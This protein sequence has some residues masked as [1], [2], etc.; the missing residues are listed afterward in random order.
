MS[1][2]KAGEERLAGMQTL[3]ERL[4][5]ERLLA[6]SISCPCFQVAGTNMNFVL[7]PPGL[8][9]GLSLPLT[10][11][12][13]LLV[14]TVHEV[15]LA[16]SVGLELRYLVWQQVRNILALRPYA[17][18]R[19]YLKAIKGGALLAIESSLAFEGL[20]PRLKLTFDL[21]MSFTESAIL[22]APMS[23]G[24]DALEEA[25][26]T[27]SAASR[28]I[29]KTA[30]IEVRG[31]SST[32]STSLEGVALLRLERGRAEITASSER[33]RWQSSLAASGAGEKREAS[34]AMMMAR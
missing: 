18:S 28:P 33:E 22:E 23:G 32:S 30:L 31:F 10:V 16:I 7:L 19:R 2:Q 5:F 26:P 9:V 17:E 6:K 3:P 24:P 14:Q 13:L 21:A 27:S 1:G 4:C 12:Q 29:R 20:E 15:A 11:S 25:S 34:P 8:E